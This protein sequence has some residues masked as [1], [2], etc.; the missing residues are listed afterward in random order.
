MTFDG[1]K[2]SEQNAKQQAYK[3]QL[4]LHEIG[5]N[6]YE[7]LLHDSTAHQFHKWLI[8]YTK[9]NRNSSA[10]THISVFIKFRLRRLVTEGRM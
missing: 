8:E 5:V 2:Q 10:V 6:N 3:L 7:E 9:T 4:I 1:G